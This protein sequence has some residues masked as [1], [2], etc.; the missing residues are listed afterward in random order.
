[1]DEHKEINNDF[2]VDYNDD[3]DDID[4]EV[5]KKGPEV[6]GDRSLT[7]E[8]KVVKDDIFSPSSLTFDNSD[9][10]FSHL[11]NQNATENMD[12][13]KEDEIDYLQNRILAL[14]EQEVAMLE[15]I[16]KLR[17]FENKYRNSL[18]AHITEHLSILEGI[19][20]YE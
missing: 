15:T 18:R 8:E 2:Q 14:R 9:D 4:V 19:E 13:D 12:M 3:N 7:L 17:E 1:M 10:I 20:N 16:S 11:D 6:L 5:I